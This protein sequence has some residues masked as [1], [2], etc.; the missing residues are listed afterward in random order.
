MHVCKYVCLEGGEREIR[1]IQC[2]RTSICVCVCVCVC[3]RM[4]ESACVCANARMCVC[5]CVYVCA[6]VQQF[7]C[8]RMPHMTALLRHYSVIRV[9]YLIHM[10]DMTHS[11]V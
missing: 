8:I 9:A 4:R 2:R 7:A 1:S 11:Y 5:V 6:C 3:V 10:C